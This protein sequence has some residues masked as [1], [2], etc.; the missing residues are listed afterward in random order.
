LCRFTDDLYWPRDLD[1]MSLL[2]LADLPLGP[3][4]KFLDHDTLHSAGRRKDPAD[5]GHP[6]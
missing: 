5:D 6:G 1:S 4:P 2:E 3:E